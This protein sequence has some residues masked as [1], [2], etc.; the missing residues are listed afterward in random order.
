[1]IRGKHHIGKQSSLVQM[2]AAL[3]SRCSVAEN[4]N[5]GQENK[6][7]RFKYVSERLITSATNETVTEFTVK[8][9]GI[10]FSLHPHALHSEDYWEADSF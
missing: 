6:A 8:A 1:M 7:I 3:K 2:C 5:H 4:S 10:T 9:S